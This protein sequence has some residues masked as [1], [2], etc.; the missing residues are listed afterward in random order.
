MCFLCVTR[1]NTFV[2]A[3]MCNGGT[4]ARV[5]SRNR[6]TVS[7]G[8]SQAR[9]RAAYSRL[10]AFRLPTPPKVGGSRSAGLCCE[11]I[12]HPS[13]QR[14]SAAILPGSQTPLRT[15]SSASQGRSQTR[16]TPAR[17]CPHAAAPA[18]PRGPLAGLPASSP[19]RP[20]R[21]RRRLY[22]QPSACPPLCSNVVKSKT[23]LGRD[24]NLNIVHS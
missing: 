1:F 24:I 12:T 22:R 2:T 15:A 14:P 23:L 17:P 18:P 5:S 13:R 21:G 4:A 6:Q 9:Q 3:V 11:Q 8:R 20:S 10:I 7:A 19:P 16:L